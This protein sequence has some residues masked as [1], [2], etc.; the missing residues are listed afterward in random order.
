[1]PDT[2]SKKEVVTKDKLE[3]FTVLFSF[4]CIVKILANKITVDKTPSLAMKFS[5]VFILIFNLFSTFSNVIMTF[6]LNHHE[7]N[8][9]YE[10]KNKIK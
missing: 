5:L 6:E 1:V 3:G 10:S 9:G 2:F 4:A 8:S 7:N